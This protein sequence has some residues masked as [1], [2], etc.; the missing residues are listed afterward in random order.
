M[1]QTYR[2]FRR[3]SRRSSQ[4]R[5][6]RPASKL[7]VNLWPVSERLV[8]LDRGEKTAMYNI[9]IMK[10]GGVLMTRRIDILKIIA[11]AATIGI[12]FYFLAH[13]GL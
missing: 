6:R 4:P 9:L 12:V 5:A 10:I 8:L 13:H 11:V 1:F 2:A 7:A 3:D